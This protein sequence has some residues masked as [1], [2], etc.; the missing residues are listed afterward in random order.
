[1]ATRLTNEEYEALA[2]EYAKNPPELSGQPGFITQLRQR[3][4]VNELLGQKYARIVN[5]S[6]RAL[7]VSPSEVIA[8]AI[9]EK[10]ADAV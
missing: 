7:S 1:M 2:E 8:S 3:A 9:R 5:E 4:L 10:F 6:A